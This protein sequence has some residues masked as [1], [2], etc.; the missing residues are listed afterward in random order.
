MAGVAARVV[1]VVEA[2]E[3]E[4]PPGVGVDMA[5]DIATRTNWTSL[6]H[7]APEAAVEH[8]AAS[9]TPP[10]TARKRAV[11]TAVVAVVEFCPIPAPDS[12][13]RETPYGESGPPNRRYLFSTNLTTKQCTCTARHS[14]CLANRGFIG[15][16]L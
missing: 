1:E 8:L 9:S 11:V 16:V 12:P 13:F 5:N 4:D 15:V 3:A 14:F 6:I 7:N 10:V 2:V